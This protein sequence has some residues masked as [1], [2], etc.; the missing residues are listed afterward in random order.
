MQTQGYAGSKK[1]R[2][3]VPLGLGHGRAGHGRAGQGRADLLPVGL[4]DRQAQGGGPVHRLV[5]LCHHSGTQRQPLHD[6]LGA[7]KH[8]VE[9][10]QGHLQ[11]Q[12][13]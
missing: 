11:H 6:V 9:A 2:H 1:G 4:H 12:K 13:V 10:L 5:G 8:L 7:V 3:R